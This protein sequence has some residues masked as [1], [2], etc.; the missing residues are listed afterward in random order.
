[1]AAISRGTLK[2]DI[3]DP[4]APLRE[5]WYYAAPSRTVGAARP[6]HARPSIMLGDPVLPWP[7]RR[8]GAVFALRDLC[9]CI[10]A[11]PLSRGPIRRASRSNAAITA[12]A[13]SRRMASA[14]RSRKVAGRRA[15]NRP[16]AA[17]RRAASYPV[18]FEVN[19]NIWVYFGADPGRGAGD[20]G[21]R[22][23]SPP[24]PF[25]RKSPETVR[26][27]AA[28][29]PRRDR[30]LMDSAHGPCSCTAPGSGDRRRALRTRSAR[31]KRSRRRR[32]GASRWSRHVTSGNSRAYKLLRRRR[33]ET[34]GDRASRCRGS[35]SSTPASAGIRWSS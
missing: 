26:F 1:M 21:T 30:G 29:A 27:D 35:G 7:R 2:R 28:I 25:R 10:A 3:D 34:G 16:A 5:A 32:T 4:A 24:T 17:G 19:G 11:L 20:P 33:S 8:D 9:A 31:E 18:Q 6:G 23:G 12:G 15:E 14:R 22:R 13:C